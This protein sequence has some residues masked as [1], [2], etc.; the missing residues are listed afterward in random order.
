MKTLSLASEP[1][2]QEII[3]VLSKLFSA[4]PKGGKVSVHLELQLPEQEN[5]GDSSTTDV[6][7]EKVT[8]EEEEEGEQEL[9]DV[10][11]CNTFNVFKSRYI[12]HSQS[13]KQNIKPISF[14][15]L[16]NVIATHCLPLIKQKSHWFCLWRVLIDL[17][18]LRA[19]CKQSKFTAQM[20]EWFPLSG[21]TNRCTKDSLY[22]YMPTHL[23]R[24]PWREWNEE[25]YLSDICTRKK[26]KSEAFDEFKQICILM[27]ASLTKHFIEIL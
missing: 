27:D 24:Y 25:K 1:S 12:H 19:D 2:L 20:Q 18:L 17:K 21:Q 22:V 11:G 8:E 5:S 26:A 3:D 16:H 6:S 15:L 23:G 10:S 4:S 13:G 7:H 9:P 14:K